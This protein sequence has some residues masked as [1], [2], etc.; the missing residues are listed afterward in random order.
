LRPLTNT[1]PKPLIKIFG[2]SILEHNLES[3]YKYVSEI[4]IVVKYKEELIKQTL[5]NSYKNIPLAYVTQSD[6]PGT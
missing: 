6:E 2:K 5:G 4:I 1:T 3:I